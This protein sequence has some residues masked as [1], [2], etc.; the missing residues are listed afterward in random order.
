MVESWQHGVP[1]FRPRFP[2]WPAI[3]EIIGEFGSK[4]MLGQVSVE[5]GSKDVGTRMEAILQKEGYY[6]GK[7]KLLQ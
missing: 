4:I 7:K 5:E 6:D 1:E 3:S 2:A